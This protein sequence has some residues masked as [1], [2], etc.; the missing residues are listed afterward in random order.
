MIWWGG[1]RPL[2]VYEVAANSVT[3]LQISLVAGQDGEFVDASGSVNGAAWA[4]DGTLYLYVTTTNGA[5]SGIYRVGDD[6]QTLEEVTDF[7]GEL[8]PQSIV[9]RRERALDG[10]LAVSPDGTRLAMIV[11]NIDVSSPANGVYVLD[12]ASGEL[13]HV[14]RMAEI[15]WGT[16]LEVFPPNEG[17]ALFGAGLAWDATGEGLFVFGHRQGL[18]PAVSQVIH[19]NL[20]TD[21]ITPLLPLGA[22]LPFDSYTLS[23]EVQATVEDL[24][25]V[26]VTMTP[27]RDG[28]IMATAFEGTAIFMKATWDGI[29]PLLTTDSYSLSMGLSNSVGANGNVILGGHLMQVGE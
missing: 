8:K 23:D 17:K 7:M 21:T 5:V 27:Q 14:V 20:S 6:W 26:Y 11:Q 16:P 2:L 3:P 25:P 19:K 13:E 18:P 22:Y 10:T 1:A 4:P 15:A 28:V 29:T 24:Y 12:L 9:I